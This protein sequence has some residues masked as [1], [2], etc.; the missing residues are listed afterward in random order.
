MYTLGFRWFEKP[1]WVINVTFYVIVTDMFHKYR[2][3]GIK[4]FCKNGVLDKNTSAS[5]IKKVAGYWLIKKR[6]GYRCFPA[7]WAKCFKNTYFEEP[8]QI[9]VNNDSEQYFHLFLKIN[10]LP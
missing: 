5:F 1:L 10:H 2:I 6:L 8:L 7:D 4:E 9:A 3:G